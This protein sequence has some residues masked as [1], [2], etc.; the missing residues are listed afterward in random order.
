MG[1]PL[2]T[3]VGD[4]LATPPAGQGGHG[5]PQGAPADRVEPGALRA[6]APRVARGRRRAHPG[7]RGVP[8][9]VRPHGQAAPRRSPIVHPPRVRGGRALPS[10]R[11]GPAE[12][13]RGPADPRRAGRPR[14]APAGPA[15]ARLRGRPAA[16]AD[17]ADP[18]SRSGPHARIGHRREQGPVAHRRVAGRA[19][20]PGTPVLVGRPTAAMGIGSPEVPVRV[21][22]AGRVLTRGRLPGTPGSRTP[23]SPRA[24]TSPSSTG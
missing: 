17:A 5:A 24:S 6:P 18:T 15:R 3:P 19:R 10:P 4:P 1:D 20:P 22:R 21:T 2:G 23:R 7:R 8:A 9:V 13:R 16:G 14:P 11:R 12:L